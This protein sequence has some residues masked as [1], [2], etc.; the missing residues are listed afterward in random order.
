MTPCPSSLPI[1]LPLTIPLSKR[2]ELGKIHVD[3]VFPH[4]GHGF[5]SAGWCWGSRTWQSEV[6][7]P[8]LKD[9]GSIALSSLPG[10]LS[11]RP[12]ESQAIDGT[13][14]SCLGP[15]GL[16]ATEV[17]VSHPAETQEQK[18]PQEKSRETPMGPARRTLPACTGRSCSQIKGTWCG[19]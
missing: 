4:Q 11:N 15:W 14:L 16:Q 19:S 10:L 1:Q 12:I 5:N 18:W 9:F 3:T 8:G 2:E 13:C 6:Q 17:L 7:V